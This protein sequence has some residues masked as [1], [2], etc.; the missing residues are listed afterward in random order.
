[1]IRVGPDDF[2]TVLE[3]GFRQ[4]D[5]MLIVGA[6][7]C[8]KTTL[9]AAQKIPAYYTA[10]AEA[11]AVTVC[12]KASPKSP[13]GNIMRLMSLRPNDLASGNPYEIATCAYKRHCFEAGSYLKMA[14]RTIVIDEVFMV[15]GLLLAVLVQ[16][17]SFVRD[18]G[19]GA[20]RLIMLGD[21][22]QIPPVTKRGN[23]IDWLFTRPNLFANLECD[24]YVIHDDINF[25]FLEE[26][27]GRLR[28]VCSILR[29]RPLSHAYI[30]L[31]QEQTS[32]TSFN[33]VLVAR[34]DEAERINMEKVAAL[35]T[36]RYTIYRRQ[37]GVNALHTVDSNY[38]PEEL[39][40]R[41]GVRLVFKF[42]D[43]QHQRYHKGS[44]GT[45]VAVNVLPGRPLR[46]QDK[47]YAD[48]ATLDVL[49]D[50][51]DS[52]IE[53]KHT[54]HRIIE[55]GTLAKIRQF[56]C[57]IGYAVNLHAA[58]GMTISGY[59]LD[60]GTAWE[61]SQAYV[62]LSR[63]RQLRDIHIVNINERLLTGGR[64]RHDESLLEFYRLFISMAA[65]QR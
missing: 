19:R 26:D 15:P 45:L 41:L 47:L 53:I 13:C 3:T 54:T 27:G 34:R 60:L 51:T 10:M 52:I 35:E 36:D 39:K 8:G 14:Y 33:T 61:L 57:V 38:I 28:E 9:V 37:Y 43:E 55:Q 31:L 62:G 21:P 24:M 20:T 16:Y 1:M 46:P 5:N 18:N 59:N 12:K 30:H 63:A 11:A 23:Q 40:L 32:R 22:F 49:L 56:P 48:R 65:S 7:G 4:T 6:A 50:G 64:H 58:Q 25:R 44:L 2:P 42:N 17:L 29:Y